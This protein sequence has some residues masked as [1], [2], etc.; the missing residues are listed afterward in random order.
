VKNVL[1]QQMIIS[2]LVVQDVNELNQDFFFLV[3]EFNLLRVFLRISLEIG[4]RIAVL[5][6]KFVQI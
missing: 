3:T 2:I 6:L 4:L 1:G 5:K